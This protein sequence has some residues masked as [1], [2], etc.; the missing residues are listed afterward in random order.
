MPMI[1]TLEPKK[2]EE[3]QLR[4]FATKKGE[5]HIIIQ[6]VCEHVRY[7][8]SHLPFSYLPS[9]RF[10]PPSHRDCKRVRAENTQLDREGFETF[11]VQTNTK[12]KDV[13][14]DS[15]RALIFLIMGSFMLADGK[16]IGEEGVKMGDL[17][18]K[19]GAGKGYLVESEEGCRVFPGSC[20]CISL[21]D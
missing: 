19:V 14:F 16:V 18:G 21:F 3:L 12:S 4:I 20:V 9:Y 6:A 15:E 5:D 8:P 1:E 17:M 13:K 10:R 11:V 2:P 7:H